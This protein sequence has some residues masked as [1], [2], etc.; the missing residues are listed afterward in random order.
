MEDSQSSSIDNQTPVIKEE[1]KTTEDNQ[2]LAEENKTTEDKTTEDNQTPAE[3][4]QQSE[5]DTVQEMTSTSGGDGNPPKLVKD[6]SY[7]DWK[8]EVRIWQI[9]TTVGKKK[10]AARIILK[11]EGKVRAH[12]CRLDL[13]KIEHDDGVKYLLGELDKFFKKDETQLVFIAIR[14]EYL[15][16]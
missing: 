15:S 2:T 1:D 8:H 6:G 5:E 12:A 16:R 11:L 14:D 3:E 10:Q 4:N 7:L 9:G 13:D